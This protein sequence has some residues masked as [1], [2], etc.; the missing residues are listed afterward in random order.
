MDKLTTKQKKALLGPQVKVGA[1]KKPV[2]LMNKLFGDVGGTRRKLIAE[3][4]MATPYEYGQGA[5]EDGWTR[6]DYSDH[7]N[8]PMYQNSDEEKSEHMKGYDESPYANRAIHKKTYG[9]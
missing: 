4:K 6:S 7:V 3:G 5:A 9:R 8:H 1:E 2:A